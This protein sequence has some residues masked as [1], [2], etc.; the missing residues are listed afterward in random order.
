M[1]QLKNFAD[2]RLMQGCLYCGAIS[3]DTREHVPSKIFL[4]KPFPDNLPV[5]AA[6]LPCNNSYSIDEEY[7]ACIIACMLSGTTEP[8]NIKISRIRDILHKKPALRSLIEQSMFSTPNY[9]DEIP[10]SMDQ[11][12]FKSVIQKLAVGHA[13][14]E[15]SLEFRDDPAIIN[16]KLMSSMSED[17]LLL[18]NSPQLIEILGEVGS[19]NVQRIMV[20][21]ILL[22]SPSTG[23]IIKAPFILN[24]W[25]DVQDG[26]Y[27]YHVV[28]TNDVVMV[29]IVFNEYIACEVQW[30]A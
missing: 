25:V 27:R 21:D 4:E 14:Y 7:V 30:G 26:V 20:V 3:P 16:W 24:D 13:A 22:Q 18:F 6:C 12:R 23:E 28:Q 17:E 29:K 1:Q 19:R 5:V 8:N 15:L 10:F 9:Q 2:Y 11:R